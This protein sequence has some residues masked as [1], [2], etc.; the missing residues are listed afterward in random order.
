MITIPVLL[1]DDNP[2]FL[3]ILARF[4]QAH[5]DIVVVG[6]AGNGNEALE[7]VESLRPQVILI[8]LAM[9]GLDGLHTIPRLRSILPDVG[10][11]VLTVFDTNGYRQAALA[12]GGDDFVPKA[13]L[14]TDLL[15]AIRR[16]AQI[17]RIQGKQSAVATD[18]GQ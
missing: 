8:D 18:P 6:T 7:K 10:I 12:T 13:V 11:I 3:G 1:V 14:N 15:P 16:L 17:A 9:P 5:D 2:I 4:L